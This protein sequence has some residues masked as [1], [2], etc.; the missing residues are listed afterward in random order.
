[1]APYL[2]EAYKAQV[3]NGYQKEFKEA[4][5]KEVAYTTNED[6]HNEIKYSP[7]CTS[8]GAETKTV[9]LWNTRIFRKE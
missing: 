1:M 9:E 4:D 7:A 3:P 2:E 6:E 8:C 5:P